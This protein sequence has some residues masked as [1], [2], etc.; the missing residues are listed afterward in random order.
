MLVAGV[1]NLGGVFISLLQANSDT[2]TMQIY[3]TELVKM[4]DAENKH[5]RKDTVIIWDNA[6]YHTNP[7]TMSLL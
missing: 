6:S 1:D 3:L 2:E 4:L 7:R 5:W